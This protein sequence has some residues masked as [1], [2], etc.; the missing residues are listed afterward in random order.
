MPAYDGRDSLALFAKPMT[1]PAI[2]TQ[3]PTAA[4]TTNTTRPTT[5]LFPTISMKTRR[6]RVSDCFPLSST[7]SGQLTT[8]RVAGEN[9]D[10]KFRKP[11]LLRYM[12]WLSSDCPNVSFNDCG[13]DQLGSISAR[14][15]NSPAKFNPSRSC[16]EVVL[17]P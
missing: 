8:H 4:P 5:T 7:S 14:G 11:P 3:M 12:R 15:S 16:R 9:I 10:Y 13:D 6:T 17:A 1:P 2:P